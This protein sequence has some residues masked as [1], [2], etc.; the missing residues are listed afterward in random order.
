[1]QVEQQR[2][3]A[4]SELII[5]WYFAAGYVASCTVVRLAVRLWRFAQAVEQDSDTAGRRLD[6]KLY[7]YCWA[8][9]IVCVRNAASNTRGSVNEPV[10]VP[11]TANPLSEAL[12][13]SWLSSGAAKPSSAVLDSWW[14]RRSSP[15]VITRDCLS[16]N[17]LGPA[18]ASHACSEMRC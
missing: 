9:F 3:S 6:R 17:A 8:S 7:S 1:M 11:P 13:I 15:H 18:S 12:V 16:S 14:L 2:L 10:L 5:F 4:P